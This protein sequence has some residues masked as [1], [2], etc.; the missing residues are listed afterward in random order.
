[1]FQC[2]HGDAIL[3]RMLALTKFCSELQKMH[4]APIIRQVLYYKVAQWCQLPQVTPPRIPPDSTGMVQFHERAN[5]TSL[6][7]SAGRVLQIIPKTKAI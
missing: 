7:Q 1:M 5:I 4:T 2:P 6:V 3:L